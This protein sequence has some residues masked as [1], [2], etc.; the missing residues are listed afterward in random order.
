MAT[1]QTFSI[2]IFLGIVIYIIGKQYSQY[3]IELIGGLTIFLTGV[4]MLM[5]PAINI[6]ATS[7]NVVGFILFGLGAYL[8]V[9]RTIQEIDPKQ[10]EEDD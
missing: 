5:N 4:V 6:D 9:T 7:N 1:L 8:W 3:P 2:L 10:K